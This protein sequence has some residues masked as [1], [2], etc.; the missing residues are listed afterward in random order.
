MLKPPI[1]VD[2]NERVE[3]LQRLDLLLTRPEA[4]FDQITEELARIFD[5]PGVVMSFIDHDTQYFK[6]V[7]GPL[8]DDVAASRTEPR[9]LSIC[10]HVVGEDQM[11]VVDDLQADERFCDNAMVTESGVRF[12]AGTP[13]HSDQ[14]HPIGTLCL[15]DTR[16]RS[17]TQRERDLLR[18]VA[19]GVM[20][21]VNLQ[22]A[23]RQLLKRSKQIQR[24]LLLAEQVQRFLLPPRRIE[25]DGW[26]ISHAYRPYEHLGGDFVAVHQ[27]SDG[28]IA[29]L[30]AD[31]SGHGTASALVTAMTKTAFHRAAPAAGSPGTL[32]GNLNRELIDMVPPGQFMTALAA[33]FDP[34]AGRVTFASAGHPFPIVVRD[35]GPELVRHRN[36]ILML[37]E[38]DDRFTNETT[39]ELAP[40]D[41]LLIYT[42]GAIEAA[43]PGG[44]RLDFE[45]L[46][47]LTGQLATEQPDDIPNGLLAALSRQAGGS[48]D[49][50]VALL[51]IELES[52]A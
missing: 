20:A 30:V 45:G 6:S 41:R 22:I 21:H 36:D 24:D 25:G 32:L 37:L 4:V 39:V 52:R 12:Y 16:P 19:D 46:L 51:L 9:E 33:F 26:R 34:A 43:G 2:D 50:D 29:V 14:G 1:P 38:P 31:V 17:F 44:R 47:Q 11:L 15:V 27:R 7:V 23:S 42:D 40:G 8:P 48:F 18:L 35:T 10:S 28:A 3:D 49:D 13:L 5:V